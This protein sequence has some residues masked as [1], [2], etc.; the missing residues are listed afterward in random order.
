MR[1][2]CDNG[3]VVSAMSQPSSQETADPARANHADFHVPVPRRGIRSAH[4][5]KHVRE[6]L[7]CASSA[8]SVTLTS[9]PGCGAST[10]GR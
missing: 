7:A 9:G 5:M 6:H 2:A 10:V 3:D 1:P 4:S 8:K